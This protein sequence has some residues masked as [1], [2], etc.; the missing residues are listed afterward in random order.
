MRNELL[1]V[2]LEA[3]KFIT[4]GGVHMGGKLVLDALPCGEVRGILVSVLPDGA[5]RLEDSAWGGDADLSR[6]RESVLADAAEHE[7]VRLGV[8]GIELGGDVGVGTDIC[9]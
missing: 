8:E 6:G 9:H 4:G 2:I 1:G 5:P 7:G 3:K